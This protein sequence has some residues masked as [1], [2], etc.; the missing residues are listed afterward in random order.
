MT[1]RECC[2]CRRRS[3][4][5]AGVFVIITI[6]T[7]ATGSARAQGPIVYP[8]YVPPLEVREYPGN[9][10]MG[11][12]R[13]YPGMALSG[14]YTDNFF[15]T[16]EDEKENFLRILSPSLA[17]QLPAQR[18]TLQMEYRADVITL[19]QFERYNTDEHYAQALANMRFGRGLTL[20]VGDTFRR[21]STPPDFDGDTREEFNFNSTA[22][23]AAYQFGRRYTAKLSYAH[24]VKDFDSS[25]AEIDNYQE[26]AASGTLYYRFLPKTW[27]LVEYY[28]SSVDNTDQGAVSTD[29]DNHRLWVGLSWEP[30]AKLRGT[31]KGGYIKRDYD[32][33]SEDHDS[34]GMQANLQYSV[35]SRTMLDLSASREIIQ[36][37]ATRGEQPFG[38]DYFRTG[39]TALLRHKLTGKIDGVVEG[40]FFN[41][42]YSDDDATG[43]ERED[44]RVSFG[45]GVDYHIKEW[46]AVTTRYRYLDN[47]SNISSEDYTENQV[48]IS[49]S[50]VF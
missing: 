38:V 15:L 17:L 20:N 49:L 34:F 39:G 32:D 4:Y 26:D 30:T 16:S 48:F 11:P 47:D 33:I 28:F 31:A 43:T 25:R 7:L 42:D 2:C 14:K 37:E 5:L 29:N 23:E 50:M 46:L 45:L 27:A 24:S 36:T 10:H 1:E 6:L 35:T 22:V 44:D 18:H 12:L 9:I 13:I 40:A 21:S 41:D 3:K 8:G 19:G